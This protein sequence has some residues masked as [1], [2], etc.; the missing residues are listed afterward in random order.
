MRRSSTCPRRVTA[1][2]NSVRSMTRNGLLRA[3]FWRWQCTKQVF[4][5]ALNRKAVRWLR[6]LVK[7]EQQGLNETMTVNHTALGQVPEQVEQNNARG[8]AKVAFERGDAFEPQKP[9]LGDLKRKGAGKVGYGVRVVFHEGSSVKLK[10]M[11][12][13]SLH[14]HSNGMLPRP[15]GGAL[16]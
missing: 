9:L 14:I 16:E 6:N 10:G 7:V 1:C 11:Q 8:A 2:V 12:V 3:T 4:C 15:F 13:A 5:E